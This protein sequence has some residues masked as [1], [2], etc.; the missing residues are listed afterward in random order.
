M[1]FVLCQEILNDRSSGKSV[2]NSRL[3]GFLQKH[4]FN[5][6]VSVYTKPQ[7]IK[8]CQ[9]YGVSQVSRLNKT[10]LAQRLAPVVLANNGFLVPAAV[11][12]RQPS[13]SAG[14]QKFAVIF[15]IA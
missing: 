11:D 14:I 8:L 4:K 13:Q 5:G 9:A 6:L 10:N 15:A 2:S 12:S 3:I 1:L 7:L